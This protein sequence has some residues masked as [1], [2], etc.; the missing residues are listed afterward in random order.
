MF[1]KKQI[2]LKAWTKQKWTTKSGKK[3]SVTGERYLPRKAIEALS[4]FEY[5]LTTKAKRKMIK[6]GKQF[7]KQPKYIANKIKNTETSGK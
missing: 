4:P 2:S 7:S 5:R 6:I 1:S 3:S